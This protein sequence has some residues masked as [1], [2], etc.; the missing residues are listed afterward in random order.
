MGRRKIVKR[1]HSTEFRIARMND[2]REKLETKEILPSLDA[3]WD[4]NAPRMTLIDEFDRPPDTVRQ[5]IFVDLEPDCSGRRVERLAV[6]ITIATGRDGFEISVSPGSVFT[7]T[8]G[9]KTTD[10][11]AIYTVT[12]PM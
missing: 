5:P 11:F 8:L 10:Q 7:E 4:C 2:V 1:Q 9:S 6:T 12:G 3:L